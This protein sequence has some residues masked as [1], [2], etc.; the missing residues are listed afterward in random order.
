MA[1]LST[2]VLS[3]LNYITNASRL[4]T[5]IRPFISQLRRF[6]SPQIVFR[7][8]ST[9]KPTMTATNCDA[10]L[11]AIKGRATYYML[12]KDAPISDARIQEIAKQ[13]VLNVPSS[14][15]AQSARLV[16]LLGPEHDVF[17]DIVKGVLREVVPTSQDFAPTEKRIGG[18]K[19]AYG[20]VI[21]LH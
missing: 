18:F 14:F 20:T 10:F 8:F 16:V 11:E 19:A 12:N 5:T 7:F 17:W 6:E 9:S 3:S 1:S 15:N 2:R 4:H 13:A 21:D